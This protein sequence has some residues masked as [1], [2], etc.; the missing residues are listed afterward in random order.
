MWLQLIETPS[1]YTKEKLKAYKSIEP[2]DHFV[3]GHVQKCYYYPIKKDIS[4]CF[5]KSQVLPSQSQSDSSNMYNVWACIYKKHR[6]ILTANCSCKAGWPV[7]IWQLFFSKLKKSFMSE[8]QMT[9]LPP[10]YSAS[11]GQ[12]RSQWKQA[13]LNWKISAEW[14]K[15]IY[16]L[17]L[18]WH[19]LMLKTSDQ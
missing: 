5:V 3:C 11:G 9:L 18:T 1:I 17:C 8:K 10:V 6:W 12:Q 4:F 14:R 13:Q 16:L 15:M 19:V 2:Y 7:A